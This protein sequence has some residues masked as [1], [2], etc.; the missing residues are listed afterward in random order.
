MS[1][2]HDFLA[3]CLLLDLEG[4]EDRI[5]RIGAVWGDAVFTRSGSFPLGKALAELDV[6]AA[7]ATWVLGHNLLDHDFPV[8]QRWHPQMR[9]LR[10][11]VV[12]TLYLSPLA[13]PEN[14]YHRLVKDYKLVTES[15][16]DPVA[17]PPLGLLPVQ[18]SVGC[19][20]GAPGVRTRRAAGLVPLLPK[21]RGTRVRAQP[22]RFRRG[23]RRPGSAHAYGA[24]RA[25]GGPPAGRWPRL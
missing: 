19:F 10:K 12:D 2:A 3:Q 24:G 8:L 15:L 22:P 13:F 16:N 21:Q 1:N 14:P 25:R 23:V 18:R 17:R 7:G 9:L 5:T 11:P 6:F 4:G 20:C